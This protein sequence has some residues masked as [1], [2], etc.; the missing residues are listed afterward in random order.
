M[1]SIRKSTL[2]KY[3]KVKKTAAKKGVSVNSALKQ[4]GL[5][6]V[7]YKRCEDQEAAKANP[8]IMPTMPEVNKRLRARV[9][10][11]EEQVSLYKLALAGARQIIAGRT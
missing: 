9:A 7:A 5:S 1:A 11:L 3:K 4:H 6:W 2:E 8:V 10:E